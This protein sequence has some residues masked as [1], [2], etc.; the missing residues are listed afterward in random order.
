M[1]IYDYDHSVR[2]PPPV[3]TALKERESNDG[4]WIDLLYRN[5]KL[6]WVY[7]GTRPNPT[8]PTK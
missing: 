3:A 2:W 8:N 7:V 6:T 5:H 1:N 4:K